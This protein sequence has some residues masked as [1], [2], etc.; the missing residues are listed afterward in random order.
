[1]ATASGQMHTQHAATFPTASSTHTSTAS[2]SDWEWEYD[3]E[4]TEDIYFTLDLTTHVPDALGEKEFARNGKRLRIATAE[5]QAVGGRYAASRASREQLAARSQGLQ[6]ALRATAKDDTIDETPDVDASLD[7][8]ESSRASHPTRSGERSPSAVVPSDNG[9]NRPGELQILGLHTT[10]PYVRYNNGFYSCHWHTDLGTQLWVSRPGVVADPRMAGH[11]LD[12]IGSSQTRL[13]GK[14]ATLKRKRDTHDGV[15]ADEGSHDAE[16]ILGTV[17]EPEL[18]NEPMVIKRGKLNDPHLDGQADFMERLS[19]IKIKRGELDARKIPLRM[20]VYYNGAHNAEELRENALAQEEDEDT[21]M[22]LD[23]G[24]PQGSRAPEAGGPANSSEKRPSG[25]SPTAER[26]E[27]NAEDVEDSQGPKVPTPA[28]R[29][30]RGH[31]SGAKSRSFLRESL[32]LPKSAGIAEASTTASIDTTRITAKRKYVRS[33]KYSKAG[34][35]Q[36]IGSSTADPSQVIDLSTSAPSAEPN[37]VRQAVDGANVGSPSAQQPNEEDADD[38][39]FSSNTLS[40]QTDHRRET[41]GPRRTNAEMDAE[42]A[43][44]YQAATKPQ[45]RKRR[46]TKEQMAAARA[47]EARQK[48]AKAA[49]RDGEAQYKTTRIS[50]GAEKEKP[51]RLPTAAGTFATDAAGHVVDGAIAATRRQTREAR[52]F[53]KAQEEAAR[54]VL[55]GPVVGGMQMVM[56]FDQPQS[57]E[58]AGVAGG[59]S[60]PAIDPQLMSAAGDG[61]PGAEEVEGDP[62]EDLERLDEGDGP[63]D[64]GEEITQD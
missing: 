7:V 22:S 49:A 53:G 43:A 33:G 23:R 47:E 30:R 12:I 8:P 56:R 46:R 11:V 34:Q 54:K 20:P 14:P 59:R 19:A 58:G 25:V 26:G 60:G 37:E 29:R 44:Q 4:E 39:V 1:M 6:S 52:D 55:E 3:A 16:D 5:K 2:V 35:N 31:A 24:E 61:S 17:Y 42:K 13:V 41:R 64:G 27:T 63:P 10:N 32:G 18:P 38:E 21:R 62:L 40:T 45:S 51:V 50:S 48:A 15:A 28:V 9:I 57:D 36:A